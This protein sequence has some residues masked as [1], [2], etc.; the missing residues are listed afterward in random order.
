VCACV[1]ACVW[2]A[3]PRKRT[4]HS[5]DSASRAAGGTRAPPPPE[6]RDQARR[7]HGRAV[8]ASMACSRELCTPLSPLSVAGSVYGDPHAHPTPPAG[9][10]APDAAC[11]P[12]RNGYAVVAVVRLSYTLKGCMLP[13]SGQSA[14]PYGGTHRVA[15][16]RR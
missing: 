10:R 4:M 15:L 8:G 5:A 11:G 1:Q 12:R 16:V 3:A 14:R 7:C 13:A 6:R 2:L 9:P